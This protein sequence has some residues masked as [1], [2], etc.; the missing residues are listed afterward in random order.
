MSTQEARTVRVT[1]KE[2]DKRRRLTRL[3]LILLI[4]AILLLSFVFAGA[5]FLSRAGRFTITLDPE[6]YNKHSISISAT[7]DFEN[8]TVMLRGTAIDNMWNI[9][10]DWLLN[11]PDNKEYYEKG[12]PTYEEFAD[13]DKVEGDHN[14]KDY[15]AYTFWIRNAGTE[16]TGY[17]G[18]LDIDSVAKGADEAMRVMVFRNGEPTVYG[19]YPKTPNI[20]YATFA[21]DEF[22]ASR[23]MV[24]DFARAQM[25]PGEKDRYTV[26]IWLEG[27]DP[28]CVNDIMG[29]AV[30]L[31]LNFKV[32]REGEDVQN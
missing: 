12:Y 32:L 5:T 2:V 19:K 4:I 16:K 23:T 17:Y 25:E 15:I 11:K 29:G 20:P 22:F 10:K 9:T 26:I 7:E 31:S 30:K 3:L 13:L 14:G 21:I 24:T 6:A 27:W 1:A 18:T 28:E 8:P